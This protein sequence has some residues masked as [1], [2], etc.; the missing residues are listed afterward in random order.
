MD[1]L[2]NK[3]AQAHITSID[4]ARIPSSVTNQMVAAVLQYLYNL[5]A[6]QGADQREIE[7]ALAKLR[8]EFDLLEGKVGYPD[9]L[10]TL[11]RIGEIPREQLPR[12]VYL[13]DGFRRAGTIDPAG[14]MWAPAGAKIYFDDSRGI[15][16]LSTGSLVFPK[17]YLSWG[18]NE[19]ED[20]PGSAE[21]GP[22]KSSLYICNNRLYVWTGR[23]LVEIASFTGE[24]GCGCDLTDI[25]NKLRELADMIAAD[26]AVGDV[27]IDTGAY[28]KDKTYKYQYMES[29]TRRVT[30][31]CWLYGCRWRCVKD[32]IC[33]IAPGYA[34]K[35]WLF[36]EGNPAFT[37]DFVEQQLCYSEDEIQMFW[38]TLTL[39]ATKYNQDVLAY[40]KA[41]DIKWERE[42]YDQKGARR[43]ISDNAW[44]PNTD[45][46]NKRLLLAPEDLDFDGTPISRII[47]KCTATLEDDVARVEITYE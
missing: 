34:T 3:Q 14:Q 25:Y 46:G 41:D 22:H 38:G 31:D 20:L 40:I 29:P 39:K 45:F 5:G 15:F 36:I 35:E 2:D 32:G 1:L 11:N 7:G 26:G 13:F 37:I 43:L 28:D 24:G 6:S 21:I 17:D 42:S 10:A 18:S 27:M 30:E 12:S 16:F 23:K 8:D 33:G 9:G 19:K 44:R 4:T 47:F